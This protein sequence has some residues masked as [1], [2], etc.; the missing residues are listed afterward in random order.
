MV[1]EIGKCYKS[2]SLAA[3][4][5]SPGDNRFPRVNGSTTLPFSEGQS[6]EPRIVHFVCQNPQ[7]L[8]KRASIATSRLSARVVTMAPLPPL[9]A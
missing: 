1:R 2:N 9:A 4:N 6:A 3:I 7:M 5:A 8:R